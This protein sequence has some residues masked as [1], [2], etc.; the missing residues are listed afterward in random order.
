MCPIGLTLHS[1]A[2]AINEVNKSNAKDTNKFFSIL[3]L[4]KAFTFHYILSLSTTAANKKT[5]S[6]YLL[7]KDNNESIKSIDIWRWEFIDYLILFFPLKLHNIRRY[8]LH[9]LFRLTK[10]ISIRYIVKKNYI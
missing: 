9:F 7:K 3:F 2:K 8:L 10:M 5:L 4:R 1:F 6:N